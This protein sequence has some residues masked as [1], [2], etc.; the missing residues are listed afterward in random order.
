MTA[1]PL[2]AIVLAAGKGKRMR[3][4][5]PKVLLEACGRPLVE[6][7]LEAL[8]P[9]NAHPTVVVCGHGA[10]QVRDALRDRDV[11]FAEQ[12][13]QLGTGHAVQCA[14]PLLEG[15]RGDLLIVLGDTPLLT[16]EELLALVDA[17]RA[18]GR[19][20]T[21]LTA[22]MDDPGSLGRIVRGR[23]GHL[24]RIVEWKDA[25]PEVRAIR[26]INTGV[27]VVDFARLPAALGR[28][29]SDNAQGEFYL[30][31]VPGMLLS[32][33]LEVDAHR[34]P[35]P[36]AALGVNTPVELE[37]ASAALRRRGTERLL[38]R[39]VWV[40]D[41]AT[42]LVDADVE[43]G[44]GT[45]LRPF[46]HVLRG[47]RVGRNC[48]IGPHAVLREGVVVGDGAVVGSFVDLRA[49]QVQAGARVEGHARL[50]GV[51][52]GAHATVGAGAV[53]DGAGDGA[54][55]TVIGD[56]AR[57][58]AGAVFVAPATVGE[59]AAVRA[60]TVVGRGGASAAGGPT[61]G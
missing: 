42:T 49:C 48:R 61:D 3:A 30:T 38:D 35:D 6:H 36:G 28:L 24:E 52:V 54:G 21:V 58:G 13:R 56:G 37:R 5:V 7:V 25:S 29:K 39:G 9:L 41:V 45:I 15:F 31:D 50:D 22:E 60:G 43:I 32:D 59:G 53:T 57:I 51:S 23:G 8:R 47:A 14:L 44:E 40:E 34:A 55:R 10:A 12:E 33:G 2:A 4:A 18:A 20:M 1:R 19:A 26:E 17:H 11:R 16:A 27:M 46:T